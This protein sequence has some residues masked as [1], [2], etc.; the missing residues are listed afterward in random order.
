MGY[1]SKISNYS[2]QINKL[3]SKIVVL[4]LIYLTEYSIISKFRDKNTSRPEKHMFNIYIM[5]IAQ[6][7]CLF[8]LYDTSTVLILD[9]ISRKTMFRQFSTFSIHF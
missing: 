6:K 7:R 3:F 5:I 1:L 9:W 4:T 8:T 2:E